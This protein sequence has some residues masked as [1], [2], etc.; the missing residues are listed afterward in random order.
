MSD[1]FVDTIDSGDIYLDAFVYGDIAYT[2]SPPRTAELGHQKQFYKWVLADSSDMSHI[3]ELAAS[4]RRI[5]VA[6]NKAGSSSFGLL[7][8][9][10]IVKQIEPITTSIIVYR[11]DAETE[12]WLDVWSGPVW[13]RVRSLPANK[14]RVTA[15]GWR[16]ILN[17]RITRERLVYGSNAYSGGEIALELL[18]YTNAIHPTLITPGTNT[19][20]QIRNRTYE[21]WHNIGQAIQE[22]TD[23]ENGFDFSID[24]LTR[25]LN[26]KSSQEYRD[27]E[28]VIFAYGWGPDNIKSFEETTDASEIKNKVFISGQFAT[29]EAEDSSSIDAYQLHE[30]QVTLQGITDT[31][32][33]AAYAAGELT[34]RATPRVSYS[35]QPFTSNERPGRVPRP[36]VDYDVGD[37]VYLTVK[38]QSGNISN[39]GLRVFGFDVSV[40]DNGNENVGTLQVTTS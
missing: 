27:L 9:D 28:D 25:E 29:Y 19:D 33:L 32:V 24:P 38:H 23:I 26:I 16:E 17:R 1:I 8:S 39:Q 30:E 2:G 6:L 37:K 12:D 36:F 3:S 22:L 35:I 14:C 13:T 10:K 7:L 20:T 11:Y 18:D 34:Y 21:K 4:D 5:Q 31:N 15:V 40:D